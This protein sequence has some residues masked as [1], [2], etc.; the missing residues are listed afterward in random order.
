MEAEIELIGFTELPKGAEGAKETVDAELVKL[1]HKFEFSKI[2]IQFK[3]HLK[4]EHPS[5]YSCHVHATVQGKHCEVLKEEHDPVK[6]IHK[7]FDA[8][9]NEI[10]HLVKK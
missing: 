1:Q 2:R 5:H 9:E 7:S 8:L 10:N 3:A 4:G 6:L